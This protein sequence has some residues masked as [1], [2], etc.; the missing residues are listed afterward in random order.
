MSLGFCLKPVIVNR[1]RQLLYITRQQSIARQFY[2]TVFEIG[3]IRSICILIAPG[4]KSTLP[5][6]DYV[7]FPCV[8]P[9]L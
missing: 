6:G 4:T 2:A 7:Y 8:L 5:R 3:F 9:L 1:N